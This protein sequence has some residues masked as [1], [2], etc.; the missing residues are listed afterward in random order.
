MPSKP[1][2]EEHEAIAISRLVDDPSAG[3]E[4]SDAAA[5]GDR[6]DIRRQVESQRRVSR[7]LR[8]GGPAAPDRLVR[9]VQDKVRE[10]YGADAEAPR[11]R[12][13]GGTARWNPSPIQ[14][15]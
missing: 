9:T 10:R 14:S 4:T 3:A 15:R 13:L 2:P 8:A 5:R 7:E 12:G 6:P 1:T 11:R